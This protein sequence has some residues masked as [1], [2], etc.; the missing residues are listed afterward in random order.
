ME[1]IYSRELGLRVAPGAKITTNAKSFSITEAL[2]LYH[3]LKGGGKTKLF[4]KS[5]E[6]S[7]RYL[8]DCLGH[9]D[10]AAIAI[11]DASRFRDYLLDRGM[12]SSSVKR[13]FSSVRAV[14]NLAIREQGL[15]I[16]NVF[17]G[18]FIPEDKAKTLRL[19]IPA[20]VLL[21]IQHEC[22]QVDDEP[23]WL[24]AL[25]IFCAKQFSHSHD[26][27]RRTKKQDYPAGFIVRITR[28]H[29]CFYSQPV[30]MVNIILLLC[31]F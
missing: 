7:M 18:T 22:V 13:V 20:D 4:F 17:S 14:I 12:S 8:V 6:R 26:Q 5:S 29:A 2:A 31:L 24:I 16:N 19:P 1:M 28:K 10:L 11:S 27:G 15:A 23:R 30:I 21:T 3:R 25:I 9:N